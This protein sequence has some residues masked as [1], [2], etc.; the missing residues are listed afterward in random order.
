M[1]SNKN[2]RMVVVWTLLAW[3]LLGAA[4]F[5]PARRMAAQGGKSDAVIRGTVWS[6]DGKTPLYGISVKARGDGKSFTTYVFTDEKGKYDFPALPLGAYQVS[7]G[8]VWSETVQLT[9]SGA[10][11]DFKVQL[12]PGL[13][14]QITGTALLKLI[15]GTEA[16]KLEVGSSCGAFGCHS[17]TRLFD[18]AP[19]TPQGW[20][21][22]LKRMQT[23]NLPSS[24][25]WTAA[26]N[27]PENPSHD[28]FMGRYSPERFQAIGEY[29]GQNITP[30]TK[31][32]YA[33]QALDLDIVRPKGEAARSVYTEWDLPPQV[34]AAG[35]VDQD[36]D[37]MIWFIA[38][39]NVGKLDPRTGET[40]MWKGPLGAGRGGGFHDLDIDKDWSGDEHKDLWLTAA[41]ADKIMKFDTKTQKF[42][43]WDTH[44]IGEGFTFTEGS[45]KGTRAVYPHTGAF[46][47]ARNYWVTLQDGWDSG[48]VKLDPRTGTM[49]KF[50]LPTKWASA[51]GDAIDQ[52]DNVWVCEY[53]SGKIAK[54]DPTGK[55][56]EYP[57]PTP[58]DHPRR[59]QVDSKGTPWFTESGVPAHIGTIDPVTGKIIEY[60]YG[61][62]T[63]D[64]YWIQID[65]FDKIWF[66]SA[67]GNLVGKF[68][69][70]TKKFVL[71]PFPVVE[72][73]AING[74]IDNRTNPIS[75]TFGVP[76]HP[77]V[78]RMYVRP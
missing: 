19:G 28:Y 17:T 60:G 75:L 78:A 26:V 2:G 18:H 8:T 33:V 65:K 34:G 41:M 51:Y 24:N 6:T 21:P 40:Q 77:K 32:K 10:N 56:T 68:D 3:V 61:I 55:I 35:A 43:V 52:N 53:Q 37:G 48:V 36:P 76:D 50:T 58:D 13:S 1:Q 72:R 11:Q 15:P 47:K 59:I 44:D 49:K 42:T 7:V 16:Q 20:D 63:G 70:V 71:F 73:Y 57:V 64:P 38:G 29:L 23:V 66:N 62:P 22:I 45:G 74:L 46:D 54:I 27:F 69:P 25:W 4:Y 12:G 67:E 31:A 5:L 9:A 39:G 30:E 14:N